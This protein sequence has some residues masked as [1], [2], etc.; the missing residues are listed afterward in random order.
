MNDVIR[1]SIAMDHRQESERAAEA[2]K[3]EALFVRRVIR[4]IQQESLVVAEGGHRLFEGD[5]VLSEVPPSLIG[6]PFE[7]RHTGTY[8][9]RMYRSRGHVAA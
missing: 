8:I 6:I 7:A 5:P 3:Y 9:L 4:I 2:N 1:I